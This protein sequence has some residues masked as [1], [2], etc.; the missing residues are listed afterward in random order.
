MQTPSLGEREHFGDPEQWVAQQ[1]GRNSWRLEDPLEDQRIHQGKPLRLHLRLAQEVCWG[2]RCPLGLS[3]PSW[4]S[5]PPS[6]VPSTLQGPL[7]HHGP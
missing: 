2:P 7:P 5:P 6:K 3:L 1:G 4:L